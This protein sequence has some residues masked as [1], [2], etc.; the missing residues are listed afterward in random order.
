MN[1]VTSIRRKGQIGHFNA[2][3]IQ[4]QFVPWSSTLSNF[5]VT[6]SKCKNWIQHNVFTSQISQLQKI[7]Y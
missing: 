2:V 4:N 6:D 1:T 5:D 7:W 3:W